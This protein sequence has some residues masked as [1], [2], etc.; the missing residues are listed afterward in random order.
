MGEVLVFSLLVLASLRSASTEEM[1][2][3]E[4]GSVTL[5]LKPAPSD[6]ITVIQW[7]FKDSILADWVKDVL[8]L[9]HNRENIKLDIVLDV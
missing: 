3:K 7:K 4:G 9:A 8:P 6:P 5:E 2:I 1:F